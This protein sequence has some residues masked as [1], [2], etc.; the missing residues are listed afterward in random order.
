MTEPEAAHAAHDILQVLAECHR[1]GICYADVKPANFLLK[2]RYSR[3]SPDSHPLELRVVD[4]GCSQRL[5]EVRCGRSGLQLICMVQIMT[6]LFLRTTLAHEA[7][8]GPAPKRGVLGLA[9][10]AFCMRACAERQAAQ[11]DRHAAVHGAGA[12]HALLRH[13]VRPGMN[14]TFVC[15]P[16]CACLG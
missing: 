3:R 9:V 2:R 1:Q 6:G 5:Q 8:C 13:R 11:A 4:F 16:W 14:L 15:C 12:I 7:G 10:S